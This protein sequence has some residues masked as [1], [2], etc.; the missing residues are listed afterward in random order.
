[1]GLARVEV[2]TPCNLL[3][4]AFKRRDEHLLALERAFGGT[5]EA[6]AAGCALA[7]L[8]APLRAR[9]CPLLVA[10]I[11]QLLAQRL[12]IVER[13]VIDGGMVAGQD[14][15]LFVVS[16]KALFEFARNGHG[17]APRFEFSVPID[18]AVILVMFEALRPGRWAAHC[19]SACDCWKRQMV[20][21]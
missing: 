5:G 11:A 9:Q 3:A 17:L 10:Q 19:R 14:G 4:D 7:A 18:C 20:R 13:D 12:Q 15:L 16:E 21:G 1:M 8:F 6:R 2:F